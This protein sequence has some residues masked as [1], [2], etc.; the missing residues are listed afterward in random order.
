LY[1]EKSLYILNMVNK[2]DLY[3]QAKELGIKK[4]SR[5]TKI[6]LEGAL[7]IFHL[8]DWFND[9]AGNKVHIE[10]DVVSLLPLEDISLNDVQM[11][12]GEE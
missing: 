10:D 11:V 7:Y 1:L 5:M 9:I 8:K 2:K 3:K 4:I 12:G 6:E